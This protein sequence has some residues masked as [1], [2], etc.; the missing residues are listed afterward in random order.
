M[1][2]KVIDKKKKAAE[3]LKN[4]KPTVISRDT[5]TPSVTAS[6]TKYKSVADESDIRDIFK[7]QFYMHQG[8]CYTVVKVSVEVTKRLVD[9]VAHCESTNE[10]IDSEYILDDLFDFSDECWDMCEHFHDI[11][12]FANTE[13][14]I[15]VFVDFID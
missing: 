14:Q 12:N 6:Q 1:F 11:K 3:V 9:I 5:A 10:D 4:I 15:E 7:S 8:Y 2:Q 13:T